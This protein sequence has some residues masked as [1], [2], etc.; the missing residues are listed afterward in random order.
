M[1]SF[2]LEAA[3]DSLASGT[4]RCPALSNANL[5]LLLNQFILIDFY[6]NR[7]Q[8]FLLLLDSQYSLFVLDQSF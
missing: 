3:L 5:R 7:L 2:L 8:L 6:N 4:I 1:S